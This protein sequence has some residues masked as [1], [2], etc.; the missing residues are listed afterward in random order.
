MKFL[1]FHSLSIGPFLSPPLTSHPILLPEIS[2]HDVQFGR[3]MKRP[4]TEEGGET[5]GAGNNRMKRNHECQMMRGFLLNQFRR[6]LMCI[7]SI[8][9]INR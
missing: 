2:F 7:P 9:L 3:P 4:H 1:C 5:R 8:D 6:T